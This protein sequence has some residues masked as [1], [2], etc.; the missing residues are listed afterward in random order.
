MQ[1]IIFQNLRL[2][3]F[4][5]IHKLIRFFFCVLNDFL[6]KQS[7]LF[8]PIGEKLEDDEVNQV[9]TDCMEPEDDDGNILYARKY[10]ST[11]TVLV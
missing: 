2:C 8:L 1:T 3:S 4:D 6:C 10:I 11:I 7:L 5:N 9:F